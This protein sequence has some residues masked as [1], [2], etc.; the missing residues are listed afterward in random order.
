MMQR[1]LYEF[2]AARG[3]TGPPVNGFLHQLRWNPTVVDTGNNATL[4]ISVLPRED[5][6]GD[7]YVV[8]S[9]TSGLNANFTDMPRHPATYSTGAD[10]SGDSGYE[11]YALAGERIRVKIG[12]TSNI[13]GR[14]YIWT[15]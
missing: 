2:S 3:D 12:S 4:T 8:Y 13:A 15:F 6:T 14:L 1:Q 9:R 7:G 11:P 10:A 5:D